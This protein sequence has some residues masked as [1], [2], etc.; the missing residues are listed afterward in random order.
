MGIKG[1]N[2]ESI[3]DFVW[4]WRCKIMPKKEEGRTIGEIEDSFA[5]DDPKK[6]LNTKDAA[7]G[8]EPIVK[9]LYE[10]KDSQ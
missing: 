7:F 10:G 9:T 1:L 4:K 5:E 2:R 6:P 3:S 8:A